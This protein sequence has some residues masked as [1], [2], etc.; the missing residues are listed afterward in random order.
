[1]IFTDDELQDKILAMEC[2]EIRVRKLLRLCSEPDQLTRVL[3]L[4]DEPLRTAWHDAIKA[5]LPS[6]S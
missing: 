5:K 4:I 2:T 1:M 3:A 6:L